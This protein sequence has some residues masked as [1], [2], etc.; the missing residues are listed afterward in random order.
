MFDMK[1]YVLLFQE[2]GAKEAEQYR[3]NK[4]PQK[5]YKF[6][7]FFDRGHPDINKRN[8]ETLEEKEVWA[9]KYFVLNDPFEFN[10]MYLDENKILASGN[11]IDTFY[12]YWRYITDSFVTVSFCAEKEDIHPL[13]NMPMWAHYAN[14]H[15]GIC[16]EYNV[17]NPIFLYPV[18][19][20]VERK[21]MS[22][23]LGKFVALALDAVNGKISGQ[24]PELIKYQ[25]L[26]WN[27]LCV[28]HR[29]WK[30]ENEFR[31]LFLC[32]GLKGKGKRVT[33]KEIGLE[34][35]AIY[36]GKDCSNRN[37]NK[38]KKIALDLKTDM[39]QMEVNNQSEKF[40]MCFRKL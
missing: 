25:F 31:V 29:S 22:V 26:V 8:I 17:C 6:M 32:P 19:Y 36:L 14:N 7:P 3:M 35:S 27:L 11:K 40:D 30:Q 2:K 28:K 1:N 10:G 9:S 21:P 23:V 12:E 15:H 39:Y 34:I 5:I 20:E 16:I 38:L 37:K 18:S 24:N 13:N 33:L 4:A